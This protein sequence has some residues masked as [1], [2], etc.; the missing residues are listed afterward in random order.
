MNI[1]SQ[2]GRITFWWKMDEVVPRIRER[3]LALQEREYCIVNIVNFS[4]A[5]ASQY[6]RAVQDLC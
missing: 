4:G 1:G 3:Q 2:K 5:V 6:P